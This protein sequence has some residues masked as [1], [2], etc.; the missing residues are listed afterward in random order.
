[1]L[2]GLAGSA[3]AFTTDF[4]LVLALRFLQGIGFAG[5]NPIV[6]TSIAD[7]YDGEAEATG[8]G[9]RFMSSGLSGAAVPLLAGTLVVVAWEYPFFLYALAVPVGMSVY[10][11]FDES[12]SQP[13]TRSRDQ[14]RRSYFR[15]L[16]VLVGQRRVFALVLARGLMTTVFIGFLTYNSLIVVRLLDG[17]PVEA[18]LLLLVT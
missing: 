2:F 18:G 17:T 3:I 13:S 4:R 8:Q 9:L 10:R 16:F 5:T 14:A 15:S 1:M 6:I 7:L 11:W 12:T